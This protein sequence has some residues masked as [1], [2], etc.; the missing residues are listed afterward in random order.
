MFVM[1]NKL[2]IDVRQLDSEDQIN[3]NIRR[4]ST[5]AQALLDSLEK[6]LECLKYCQQKFQNPIWGPQDLFLRPDF[7]CREK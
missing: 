4:Y 3:L 1:G 5:T 7:Y 2:K 6:S